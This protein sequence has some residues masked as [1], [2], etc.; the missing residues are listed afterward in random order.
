MFNA[1]LWG[2]LAASTLV[3]GALISLRWRIKPG[4][5]GLIMAFGV[6]VLISAVSFE[7]IEE[8]FKRAGVGWGLSAGFLAGVTVFFVGNWLII[9][10]GGRRRNRVEA[11]KNTDS[12]AQG[13]VLGAILDGIPESVVLGLSVV[14]GGKV[15]LAMMIAV[16]LSNLPE[17]IGSSAGL[18]HQ[19]W[20]TIK[21][22]GLWLGVMLISGLAAVAG[23][24]FFQDASADTMAFVLA[25]SGGALLTMISDTMMPEAFDEA[26]PW[27]GVATALGFGVA[28]VIGLIG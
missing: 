9:R 4:L 16:L 18:K 7:L 14:G 10:Q 6:G 21:I 17:S 26:G 12:A 2:S 19:G 8:A 27:S 15:G 24:L 22:I 1:W 28:F 23:F 20:S 5:L 25:F 11:H 13:I 3:V